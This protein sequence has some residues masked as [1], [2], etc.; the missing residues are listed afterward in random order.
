MT[1]KEYIKARNNLIPIAEKLANKK[2]GTSQGPGESR[3]DW[4]RNWSLTF[5]DKMDSLAKEQGLVK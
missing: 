4:A 3:E 2:H 5:H 1:N